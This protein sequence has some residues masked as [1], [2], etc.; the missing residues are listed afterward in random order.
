[1][2]I[3][4]LALSDQ[5]ERAKRA[6]FRARSREKV[7]SATLNAPVIIG[8][9]VDLFREKIVTHVPNSGILSILIMCI[10]GTGLMEHPT[11]ARL[12]K[13]SC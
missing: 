3:D 9:S 10:Y 7:K 1:M 5:A 11:P 12:S 4:S 6:F 2:M 13:P 8:L